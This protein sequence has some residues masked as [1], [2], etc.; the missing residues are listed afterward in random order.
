MT[1]I[2]ANHMFLKTAK[3]SKSWISLLLV[4]QFVT[5]MRQF[6]RPE[7]W[8]TQLTVTTSGRPRAHF[9]VCMYVE[10]CNAG[11]LRMFAML[12]RAAIIYVYTYVFG[13]AVCVHNATT[14]FGLKRQS[15]HDILH[16]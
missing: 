15:S 4:R 14:K 10:C 11:E 13:G 8:A 12:W 6:S 9:G 1:L 2:S 5:K 3:L 16:T 7:F